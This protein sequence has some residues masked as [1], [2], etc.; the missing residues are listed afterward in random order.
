MIKSK[1][2]NK[3]VQ[4]HEPLEKKNTKKF[5]RDLYSL[6]YIDGLYNEHE[7]ERY[8]P[9]DNECTR[10]YNEGF[11]EGMSDRITNS[12]KTI[13][14]K[15]MWL[16]KLAIIDYKNG[17]RDRR[18]SEEAKTLYDFNYEDLM[19]FGEKNATYDDLAEFEEHLK[20]H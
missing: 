16:E 3:L 13:F 15:S 7:Y 4:V 11:K 19:E 12:R 5:K 14:T 18:L 6:G 1:E 9:D 10:L 17:Y 2:Y 20:K 8:I